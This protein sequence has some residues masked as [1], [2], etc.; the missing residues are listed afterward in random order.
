MVLIVTLAMPISS[1]SPATG[2]R[3]VHLREQKE[4]VEEVVEAAV[5][6][7]DVT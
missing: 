3:A 7:A 2:S 4:L 6:A 1:A 5:G